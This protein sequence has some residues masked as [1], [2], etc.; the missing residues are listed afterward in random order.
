MA[1]LPANV[2][3]IS[4]RLDWRFWMC[5]WIEMLERLAYYTL[6]PVAAIYIMQADDPG[7]LHLT[8]GDRAL[9]FML[10]ACVQSILPTFTGGLADRY[11]YKRTIAVSLLVNTLGYVLMAVLRFKGGFLIGV[12]VLATGTAFFKPG[13]QGTIAHTLSKETSSLGWGIFYFLVNVGSLVGHLL[14]PFI[15]A[16][17]HPEDWRNMFLF[18]AGFTVLNLLSLVKFPNIPSGASTQERPV[19]VLTRTIR[20]VLEPRLLAWLLIM[21]CFWMMMFQLWDSQPNFIQDWVDSAPVAAYCPV[22]GWVETGPDGLL[23]VKQ[24]VILSCNETMVI[25]FVM[26]VSWLVRR[27][28]TLSALLI[29]MFACTVGILVAGLT[30]SAWPLL[31]GIVFFSFGEMLTGP[32]T[33]EYLGLIA[34]PTKKGLYLG[35]ANIPMGVGQAV[36]AGLAGWLYEHYGE[37]ATMALRYLIEH[38]VMGQGKAWDGR[39]DHLTDALGVTRAEAFVKLQTVL[40]ESGSETTRLLWNTYH[41]E[42]YVW[43]PFA[44]IGILAMVALAIFGR[45]ARRWSDMNV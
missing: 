13:L 15:L 41:P 27:M 31:I 20:N 36:G 6:R 9:I 34:P 35:Y 16:D 37:K 43:I 17:H 44:I 30:C 38:T 18:C 23:R 33:A 12:L 42:Y 28:R 10:W 7:G 11:G 26:P 45:M 22:K 32:K 24:Q 5:N 2:R 1:A 4:S 29:G 19:Q 8:A 21:S 25:L 3:M 14:S 40:G 39:V